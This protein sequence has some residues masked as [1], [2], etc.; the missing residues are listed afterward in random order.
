MPN[1]YEHLKLEDVGSRSVYS[2][3]N[4]YENTGAAADLTGKQTGVA[5]IYW[6]VYIPRTKIGFSFGQ[7]CLLGFLL[8]LSRPDMSFVIDLALKTDYLFVC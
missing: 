3:L 5:Y 8:V 2:G 1:N 7:V 6:E 4:P